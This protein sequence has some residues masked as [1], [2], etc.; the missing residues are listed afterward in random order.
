[1]K[2]QKH[3]LT[4]L[5]PIFGILAA[6]AVCA[7]V[8]MRIKVSGDNLLTMNSNLGYFLAVSYR[9]T[10]LAAAMLVI[11]FAALLATCIIIKRKQKKV[12]DCR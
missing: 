3:I 2:K 11:I 6:L 7:A 12:S 1:M 5:T 8:F 10:A 4:L 9:W